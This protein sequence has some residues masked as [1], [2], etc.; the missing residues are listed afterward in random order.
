MRIYSNQLSD[1]IRNN[2]A[3]VYIISSDE[4]YWY[5][6]AGS[7]IIQKAISMGFSTSNKENFS[8]DSISLDDLRE[9]LT[10]TGLF[11]DNIIVE[12]S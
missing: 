9:A 12:V 4:P 6:Y 5:E 11:A 10:S 1:N 7:L 2:F 8:D 3:K